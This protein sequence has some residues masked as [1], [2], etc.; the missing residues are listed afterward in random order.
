MSPRPLSKVLGEE[1]KKYFNKVTDS[2]ASELCFEEISEQGFD[3]SDPLYDLRNYFHPESEDP[4]IDKLSN[5]NSVIEVLDVVARQVVKV[6]HQHL[7]QAVATIH[8]LQ[9]LGSQ[10]HKANFNA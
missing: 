5:A 9:K 3:G 1:Q 2:Q 7:T 4:I 8:H 10:I 6:D